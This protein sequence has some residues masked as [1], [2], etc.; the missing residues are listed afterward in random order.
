MVDKCFLQAASLCNELISSL[1]KEGRLEEAQIIYSGMS[2][3]GLDD[4]RM[5]EGLSASAKLW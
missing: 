3:R 4:W 2:V 5:D 1:K